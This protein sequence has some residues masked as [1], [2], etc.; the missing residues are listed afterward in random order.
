MTDH[1][2]IIG[3]GQAGGQAAASL[4]QFKYPGKITLVGAEVF[5]PYQRPPLSKAYLAGA[6][7][8]ERLYLKPPAFYE[9]AN[10]DVVLNTKI[11][12]IDKKNKT[13]CYQDGSIH[14][15][16]KLILAT[17]APARPLV[18]AGSELKNIYSLRT[19]NDV[20]ALQPQL[21]KDKRL[22][23]IGAGYIGL[24]VAAAAKK[25]GLHVTVVEAEN[26]VLSRVTGEALSRFY[27]A[28]HRKAGVDLRLG[29]KLAHFIGQ[30][31]YFKNQD[32]V[33][34]AVLADGT[35]LPCDFVLTG[36][37]SLPATDLAKKAGLTC[38]NGIHVDQYCRTSAANIY[39][40][41]DCTN[42]PNSLLNGRL[43]L[44]SVH[45][46]IEQG[47]TAAA[48]IAG[49]DKPYDQVPWFW[50]DQYG[51]KLQ[52]VG[53]WSL[54]DETVMRGDPASNS[55]SIFYLKAGQLVC[56][57]AVNDPVS[58]ML[59]KKAIPARARPDIDTLANP[60]TDIKSLL[61]Q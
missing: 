37:G 34:A 17:G 5:P 50:S 15:W 3:A 36:I 54:A 44:E 33:S 23:I 48:H 41:G 8:A 9:K 47:K 32:T 20:T 39:A 56:V 49:H 30:R 12:K 7:A 2:L 14:P 13:V 24:E 55:F 40:I 25:H 46:A 43:R 29:T 57:D 61:L 22:V 51:L 60:Q 42:Q 4:R 16:T 52:T 35:Q 21:K 45:N 59:A 38:Q 11:T 10:I 27:E 6:L 26:R 1:T 58:F 28:A 53:L 19:I 18:C 31:A